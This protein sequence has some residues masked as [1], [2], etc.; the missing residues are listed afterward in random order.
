MNSVYFLLYQH[1]SCLRIN[2]QVTITLRGILSNKF[3][4]TFPKFRELWPQASD[5][6]CIIKIEKTLEKEFEYYGLL[7]D[8]LWFKTGVD[9]SEEV[10]T[11]KA[12]S[13][14][15]FSA[16]GLS[17]SEAKDYKR[18]IN[19]LLDLEFQ[20]DIPRQIVVTPEN[21][22]NGLTLEDCQTLAPFLDLSQVQLP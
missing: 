18:E 10:L 15:S 2:M 3:R 17:A 4:K 1:T 20:I 14:A 19:A 22:K 9:I 12:A 7:M 13:K 5:V 11:K 16:K 8:N 21:L 6:F